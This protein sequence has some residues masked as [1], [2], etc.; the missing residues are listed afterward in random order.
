[1]RVAT[2]Y[3]KDERN[4]MADTYTVE[5]EI[6]VDA[7]ASAVYE[8][9]VDFH[10]WRAWSPYE[11]LDPGMNRTYA[12]AESGLGAVYEW[13]GNL[14]A[15]SGRMEI[16]DAVDN[17]R[18]VIDQRNLKPFRSEA[19]TTFALDDSGDGTAVTW[20]ITGPVTLITRI[21]SIF[22]SMDR[23]VGPAFEKGLARLKADAEAARPSPTGRDRGRSSPATHPALGE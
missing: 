6:R 16:V 20:S 12:G 19:T 11:E 5:R 10:R 4:Q 9:I 3:D 23:M 17:E 2:D 15:G 13:S 7:P 18:V 14:K 21:M 1:L 8:R 22:K